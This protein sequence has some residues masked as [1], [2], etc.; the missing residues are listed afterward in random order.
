MSEISE[1]YRVRAAEFTRRVDAVPAGRWDDPSPC[2]GWSARD[3]LAHMLDNHHEMPGYA[4]I[5]LTVDTSV[6]TDPRGAW[7]EARDKMQNLLEDPGRA[8]AGYDG[9]FGR[10]SVSDTVDKFL[11]CDLVVHA[12]DIARATGQDEKLP[13]DEA[14]TFFELMSPFG[15]TLRMSGVCGPEVEVPAEASMQDRLLGL[16]GRVP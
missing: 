12:W 5:T 4:G 9:Y 11:G 2:A 15:D 1:R 10:T 8:D 6:E 16:M 13:A 14:A 7:T 3:V